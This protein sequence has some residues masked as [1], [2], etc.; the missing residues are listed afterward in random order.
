MSP[1]MSQ[2]SIEPAEIERLREMHY[3]ATLMA[4]RSIH[5]DLR[6]LRVVPDEGLPAFEPSQFVNL[7]LG[8]WERRVEG[9][10]E[11][12]MDVVH[13]QP[14]AKR[15][16]SISCSLVGDDGVLQRPSDFPYLEFYVALVRH[17]Q[18]R[19]PALTPRLYALQVG[20]RLFVERRAAGTYTLGG[21][22]P[23]DN[24]FFATVTGE[25]PHNAMIAEL[26]SRG[27]RGKVVS[28]VSVRYLRD[29]AYRECH[30]RLAERYQNYRYHV[31]TTREPP[32][33]SFNG[34]YHLQ[35]LVTTG[36]LER[37][38]G[39][40]LDPANPQFFLC[41]NAEMIRA[42]HATATSATAI[43]AGSMLD[44]LIGRGFQLGRAGQ[45]GNVHFER[46]W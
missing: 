16:Y 40:A 11:E 14:L 42:Q 3:N 31:L 1:V 43:K 9:V 25:A 8:N 7:A 21:V 20:D 35:D 12:Q 36:E 6:I 45:P 27:H 32:T 38:S 18:K 41:G 34:P 2:F 44:V 29:A 5:S 24:V 28:V 19:A 37:Q 26:L 39:V 15:A 10:D 30:E 13:Y 22:R 33:F 4:V 23:D 17:A 46:Y